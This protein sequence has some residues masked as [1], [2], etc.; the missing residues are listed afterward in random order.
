M[1]KRNLLSLI[2]MQAADIA[3]IIE[4]TLQRKNGKLDG[5]RSLKGK[6]VGIHFRKTS[7]RT[8]SAFTL[9]ANKLGASVITYGP[10]DL[11]TNT[12]ETLQDTAHILSGYI[13]ALV[14]RTAESLDEMKILAAQENMSVI[15]AMSD[16]EHP[17]QALSDLATIQ[18]HFG[19]L[20]DLHMLYLGEGN[21]TAAALAL[22]ISRIP[23]MKLTLL[24]P[25]GYELPEE[26]YKQARVFA[27][28]HGASIEEYHTLD[29]L[30][31]SAD[32]VY[33]TR[34][35]T[36]GS[37]KANP[38][39]REHF[40]PFSVTPT[41]MKRVAKSTRTIFMHDLPAVRNEEVA[42]EVL[43]G[44]Q[45]IAFHQAHNKLFGAMATLEWC[46]LGK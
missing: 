11:Q 12:G 46:I 5:E 17:T 44:P 28:K 27:S 33:T 19:H 35:Q 39:W 10:N 16:K 24:T 41:L 31:G 1:S 20:D 34:W 42:P 23:A 21:S 37:S 2:D 7:T 6:A 4:R 40:W 29:A 36:T 15:N 32:I 9:G 13:D 38:N 3:Y 18:E 22:A 14:L 43:D 45:S 8:R 26:M 25:K 30:P